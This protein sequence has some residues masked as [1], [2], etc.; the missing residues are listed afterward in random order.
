MD[1][2]SPAVQGGGIGPV[3]HGHDERRHHRQHADVVAQ[4]DLQEHKRSRQ[5]RRFAEG[6][7]QVAEQ[8]AK[9]R[10]REGGEQARHRGW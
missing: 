3:P 7:E 4:H 2:D 10:Q 1:V 8:R 6:K 9:R 5:P